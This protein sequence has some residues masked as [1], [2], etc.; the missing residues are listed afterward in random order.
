VSAGGRVLDVTGV[1]ASV[2]EARERAYAAV[3]R[4]DLPGGQFRADIA[5][6]ALGVPG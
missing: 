5:S 4:I 3:E 1:G 6:R 2:A